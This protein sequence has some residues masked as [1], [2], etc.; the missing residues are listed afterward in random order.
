VKYKTICSVLE[1]NMRRE[2]ICYDFGRN[3]KWRDIVM[4][5]GGKVGLKED[6]VIVVALGKGCCCV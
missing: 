6:F 3:D 1:E 5:E 4:N 2:M